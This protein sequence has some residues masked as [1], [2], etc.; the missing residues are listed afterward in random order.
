MP[1]LVKANIVLCS[2]S[3]I[4]VK[5]IFFQNKIDK[6][7]SS[8]GH[9]KVDMSLEYVSFFGDT[10]DTFQ[11]VT[12]K[13]LTIF[14]FP[15]SCNFDLI[16]T[17]LLMRHYDSLCNA[18]FQIMNDS[19]LRYCT[20]TLQTCH[21]ITIVKKKSQLFVPDDLKNYTPVSNHAFI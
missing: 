8:V 7:R 14:S 15:R 5:S 17:F 3:T 6:I 21:Y 10:F 1:C 2:Q 12:E 18:V 13:E 19:G 16:P 4:L 9:C 11:I 20:K